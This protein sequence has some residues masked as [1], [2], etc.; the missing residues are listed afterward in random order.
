[1][2]REKLFQVPCSCQVMEEAMSVQMLEWV[3][4]AGESVPTDSV[5]LSLPALYAV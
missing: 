4:N 2:R 3:G 5:K 1:M